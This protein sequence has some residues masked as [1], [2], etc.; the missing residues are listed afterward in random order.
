M[1]GWPIPDHLYDTLPDC[2]QIDRILYCNPYILPLR[3]STYYSEV[4]F[5]VL[6]FSEA[7]TNTA[8]TGM[9]LSLSELQPNKLTKALERA[10]YS[11]YTHKDTQ[12]S[13]S[14]LILPD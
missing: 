5:N 13:A 8:W 12:P 7:L 11:A 3:A 2:F 6:F 10:I 1:R 14:I 4:P 9:T